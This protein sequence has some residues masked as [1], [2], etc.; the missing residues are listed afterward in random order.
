MVGYYYWDSEA[1]I[2]GVIG[3]D[4]L[5]GNLGQDGN[6]DRY[7]YVRWIFSRCFGTEWAY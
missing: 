4:I 7:F 2:L 3:I 5:L 6:I 1:E